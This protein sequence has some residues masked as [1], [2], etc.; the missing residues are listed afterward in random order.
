MNSS[1]SAKLRSAWMPPAVAQAPI[2]TRDF[3]ARRTSLDPLGVVRRGDRALDEREVV[4]TADGRARG[5]EE[6]GD[7]DRAGDASSSSSQSSRLSWQPSQEAN[8]QTASLGCRGCRAAAITV[9]RT[10]S[11]GRS[12]RSAKTGP[13]LQTKIG[14]NWQCPQRPTAHFMLRSSET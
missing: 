13:S 1:T 8:F 12:G 5:L 2:V 11:N 10:A 9:S 3:E 6:V 4:G 14:P 7:L